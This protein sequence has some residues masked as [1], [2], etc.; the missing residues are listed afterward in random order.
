M[1]DPLLVLADV[2]YVGFVG[3]CALFQRVQSEEV[4]AGTWCACA[5][6]RRDLLC[7]RIE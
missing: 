5:F 1:E 7:R 2:G 3:V 6:R 4:G